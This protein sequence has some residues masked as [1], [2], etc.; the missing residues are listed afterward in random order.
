[1]QAK[2]R[3]SKEYISNTHLIV[4]VCV[5]VCIYYVMFP[6]WRQLC[7]SCYNSVS[8]SGDHLPSATDTGTKAS[9][10]GTDGV[11]LPDGLHICPIVLI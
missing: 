10:D 3:E 11:N 9:D 8:G 4:G 7:A 5:R 1:M 6:E 2:L